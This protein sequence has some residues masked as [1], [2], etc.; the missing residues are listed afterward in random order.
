MKVS[1]EPVLKIQDR[2]VS[3]LTLTAPVSLLKKT[4]I[5]SQVRTWAFL[6]E[7]IVRLGALCRPVHG[8]QRCL[9]VV[10]DVCAQKLYNA[11]TTVDF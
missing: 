11:C 7:I 1:S 10:D 3:A 6:P 4:N 2:K 9:G 5:Q 8:C